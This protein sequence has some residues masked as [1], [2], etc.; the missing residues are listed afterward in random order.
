MAMSAT[1]SA[2]SSSA[3]V[4]AEPSASTAAVAA[5]DMGI[6]RKAMALR[7][8]YRLTTETGHL[9][10]RLPL[11]ALSVHFENRAGVYPQGDVV[12]NLGVKLALKGFCQEEADHQG[13]CVQEAP[14]TAVAESLF[15]YNK[16]K[17]EGQ[18][19]LSK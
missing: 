6:I 5:L 2:A 8:K 11:R 13:V 16:S 7:V 15:N 10:R 3:A 4:A 19:A 14:H 17:C 18:A 12:K 1:G 9:K